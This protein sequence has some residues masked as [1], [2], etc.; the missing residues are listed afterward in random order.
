MQIYVTEKFLNEA[1]KEIN[2]IELALNCKFQGWLDVAEIRAP[3]PLV[4]VETLSG[5]IMIDLLGENA[6]T[7][8]KKWQDGK[9]AKPFWFEL[10]Y[11]V[12]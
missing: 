7:E 4:V 11:N 8:F 2:P 10:A 1:T 9:P 3:A 12:R 5:A 6:R